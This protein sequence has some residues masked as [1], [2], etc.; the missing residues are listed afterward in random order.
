MTY[1]SPWNKYINGIEAARTAG[2]RPFA[3][4]S[5]GVGSET[6]EE[7]GVANILAREKSS[8]I[9]A[10]GIAKIPN[11]VVLAAQHGLA[12]A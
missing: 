5:R 9:F 8:S 10:G 12:S 2:R 4:Y 6:K 1:T 3:G 11:L 7:M